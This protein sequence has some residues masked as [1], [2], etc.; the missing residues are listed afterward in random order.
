[1]KLRGTVELGPEI[2]G[3]GWPED[4]DTL[5][6]LENHGTETAV[7]VSVD[8]VRKDWRRRRTG[9]ESFERGRRTGTP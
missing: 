9:P 7:E 4:G 2:E 6:W 1:V 3:P 8:I 5:H